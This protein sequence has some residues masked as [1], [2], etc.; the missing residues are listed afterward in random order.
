M[1]TGLGTLSIGQ[2]LRLVEDIWDSIAA[3]QV[4]LPLTEEQRVELDRRLD[5]HEFDNIKGRESSE[6]LAAIKG[7]L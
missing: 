2:K 5:A 6:V 1:K 3:D 7:R 4:A